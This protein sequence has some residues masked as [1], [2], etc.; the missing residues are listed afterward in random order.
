MNGK[1]RALQKK[2]G[3]LAARYWLRSAQIADVVWL[4]GSDAEYGDDVVNALREV[5]V[6][7]EGSSS[8]DFSWGFYKLVKSHVFQL[9]HKSRID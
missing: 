9:V 7:M 4:A 2:T 1:D 6:S 8:R 5:N 3:Q